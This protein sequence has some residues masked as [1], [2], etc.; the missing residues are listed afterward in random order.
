MPSNNRRHS[1]FQFFWNLWVLWASKIQQKTGHVLFLLRVISHARRF[2][3]NMDFDIH[4]KKTK[5]SL[6]GIHFSSEIFKENIKQNN[7]ARNTVCWLENFLGPP[8]TTRFFQFRHWSLLISPKAKLRGPFL[9]P[10]PVFFRPLSQH[11]F[12]N[13][14][15]VVVGDKAVRKLFF[16]TWSSKWTWSLLPGKGKQRRPP[17]LVYVYPCVSLCKYMHVHRA[18]C[19]LLYPGMSLYLLVCTCILL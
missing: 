5:A 16:K 11:A 4:R 7:D 1:I 6:T 3:A 19:I 15:I 13:L 17:I 12:T 18:V 14:G 2:I 10:S 8:D 9:R